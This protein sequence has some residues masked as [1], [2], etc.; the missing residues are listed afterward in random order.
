[1]LYPRK[2]RR[3]HVDYVGWK[4]FQ[5]T[6]GEVDFDLDHALKASWRRCLK[7]NV[8]ATPRECWDIMP[9]EQLKPFS[10]T[11]DNV[12]SNVVTAVY[13]KIKRKGLLLTITNG[14]GRV[15]RVC[16]DKGTLRQ[17]ESL[18]FGPGANWA[19]TSVGTNAIGTALFT[20]HPVQ[21][22]GTEH[23]CASHHDWNCTAAP[24]FDLHGNIWGC[25]DIS[26]LADT[27]HSNLMELVL[28]ATRS[29]EQNLSRLYCSRLEGQMTSLFSAMFN[30]VIT[31][32]VFLNK[33]G[34]I[35][36][37]NSAAQLL[38]GDKTTPLRGCKADVLFDMEPYLAKSKH[39]SFHEPVTLQCFTKPELFVQA[40]PIIGPNGSW[41]ETAIAVSEP[42][43]TRHMAVPHHSVE[44]SVPEHPKGFEHVLYSSTA[45]QQTVRQAANAS[46]TPSTVLLTGE[47]G[48]GKELFARGIHQSGSRADQPFVAVNCGA[49]S[50]ELVQS[51]LFG[52]R[53]GAFTGAAKRGRGGKFQKADKGV[54]FLDEISEMPLAQQVKLLRALEER[55]VVP[56]GG[57][58]PVP[59]D[60]K[61]IAATNK[62]L[63]E[64]IR[65]GM[66]RED[67]YY[68]LN[69]V[70]IAIP[71]LRERG[72]DVDILAEH[73]LERLCTAFGFACPVISPEAKAVLK[74]YDWPGNV[75]ELVNC[76]E[77]AV[78]NLSGEVLTIDALPP[79]LKER[80]RATSGSTAARHS[81][82]F[83]LKKREENAIREALSF[84]EGNISKTASALGIGRN[85]LYGKIQRY[86]IEI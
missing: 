52:Y 86:H 63:P 49:F 54:L 64:L 42:Q 24:I 56:V 70:G 53:E 26:G 68:R 65:Q 41:F 71:P 50:E 8:D 62:N 1:M 43:C 48:T 85:T 51:E 12:C 84:H 27:D 82:K 38:L 6:Q 15:V 7:N 30:S 37:V 14:E 35:T 21:V 73:H 55:A 4:Q 11:L 34:R 81:G 18:N 58:T 32:M 76:L 67:L 40:I 39:A 13:E 45:M 44:P 31:G 25:F 19:E 57:T 33:Q 20:G 2:Q 46:R 29:L 69:V 77:Y 59:V 22:F 3:V 79:V 66:F 23:Y 47:S 16:G 75:R 60:V 36:S 72:N 83:E 17:A 74:A 78:N 9:M 61:I 5:D 80:A 10:A 28:Q